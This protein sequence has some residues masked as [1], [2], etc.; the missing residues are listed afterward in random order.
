MEQVNAEQAIGRLA[1]FIGE[2]R[3]EATFKDIP[4]TDASA[5]A[6]FEMTGDIA[7]PSQGPGFSADSCA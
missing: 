3:M 7:R 4:A 2:W 6:V 1:A 5:V